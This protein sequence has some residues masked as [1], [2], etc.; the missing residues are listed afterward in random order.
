VALTNA[1]FVFG[2]EPSTKLQLKTGNNPSFVNG[3][4][5]KIAFTETFDYVQ[6]Q[7]GMYGHYGDQNS[8]LVSNNNG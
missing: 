7:A 1:A 6:D 8:Y 2:S 3:Y 4:N 5:A